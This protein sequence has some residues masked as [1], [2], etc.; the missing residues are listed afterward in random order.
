MA[1]TKGRLVQRREEGSR[2][3]WARIVITVAAAAVVVIAI[4]IIIAVVTKVAKVQHLE[5]AMAGD[6]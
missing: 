6:E 2:V 4:A 5:V 1:R 3:D